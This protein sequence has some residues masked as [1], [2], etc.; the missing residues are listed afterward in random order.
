M[1]QLLINTF[2]SFVSFVKTLPAS[3]PAYMDLIKVLVG[4]V[5]WIGGLLGYMY[6]R[7]K[8]LKAAAAN[9]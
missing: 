2:I 7:E 8:N 1:E 6:W 4:S 9:K 5:T 3:N